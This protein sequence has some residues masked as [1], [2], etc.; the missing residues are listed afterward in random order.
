LLHASFGGKRLKIYRKC[1][2]FEIINM[3]LPFAIFKVFKVY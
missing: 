1:I 2:H 3:V